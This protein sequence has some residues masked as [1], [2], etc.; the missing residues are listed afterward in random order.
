VKLTLEVSA[1]MP[2]EFSL[3]RRPLWGPGF[4]FSPRAKALM[5][6]LVVAGVKSS[7]TEIHVKIP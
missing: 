3:V 7:Y 4:G 2:A 6:F 1:V 5:I